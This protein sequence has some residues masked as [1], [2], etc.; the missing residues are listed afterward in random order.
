MVAE[1]SVGTWD[2]LA[3]LFIGCDLFTF[4]TRKVFV[5]Q[6]PALRGQAFLGL[7]ML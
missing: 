6:T 4:E 5:V 2:M 1:I 7:Y 3:A